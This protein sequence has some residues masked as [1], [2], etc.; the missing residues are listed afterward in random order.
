LFWIL[1]VERD[2]FANMSICQH[3]ATAN[4]AFMEEIS[5]KRLIYA[6]AFLL[7]LLTSS[8]LQ[9]QIKSAGGAIS[10]PANS[11]GAKSALPADIE[12][13]LVAR[14]KQVLDWAH[15]AEFR[16]EPKYG[17]YD[18]LAATA[19]DG[20]GPPSRAQYMTDLGQMGNHGKYF[21]MF[22]LPPLVRYLYMYPKCMSDAQRK[23][24]ITGLTAD[25]KGFFEHGTLNH[26][27]LQGTSWYLLA[28]YFPDAVWTD[29][30]GSRLTSAQIMAHIKDLMTRRNWR[31]FQSGMSEILSPTYSLTNLYPILNMIDFGKDPQL[32]KQAS[33][34]ASLEVLILKAHS[35][36]G[37]IMPPMTRHNND[38]SNAPM[39]KDWPTNA[40]IAQ[41]E[42][43]Y[44]FGEPQ[45][46]PNDLV[47]KV[48]EP[49]FVV[50]L[51][52]SSWRPPVGAWTMPVAN[53]NVRLNTPDFAKWDN[54][55]STLAFGDTWIGKN[56]ALAT[57]N[58]VFNPLGYND[59]NQTFAVAFRSEARRNL[60]E[61]QQPYW[62]SNEGEN[63]W[64]G[65]FWSPFMQSWRLDE[66]RAVL[67][68]SVPQKDP[69]TVGVEDR[70]WTE[71]DKH[72]NAL[73]QFVQCRI[74]KA[75]DEIKIE[76]H[77]V[78][79][80]KGPT[81]VALGSLHGDFETVKA[82]LPT[83]LSDDFTVVKVD[84]A[85]TALYV[86]ADDSGGTFSDFRARAKASAPQYSAAGPSITAGS[87][88]VRF[89]TP[90]ADPAPARPGTWLA[91][92][93]VTVNGQVQTYKSASV[94]ESPFLTLSNG[95]LKLTGPHPLDI[96]G[97][98]RP[99]GLR[100]PNDK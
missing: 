11:A 17:P 45:I 80:R 71:R 64:S 43:W 90:V 86:M 38:Q 49:V 47:N 24:L 22:A 88:T 59:H 87:T 79:F 73:L 19:R 15:E 30:N 46:G 29:L 82:G 100:D 61:C 1:R 60:L 55:T 96:H 65:D 85:K 91:L 99:T 95:E 75:V 66:H 13:K 92:P 31:S 23:E 53:Y 84:Q 21:E 42:L 83:L 10:H 51:A 34:E 12:A 78:F 93:E 33:D 5:L 20:C 81:Y 36:H 6:A 48:R 72:A 58:M 62:R 9:A 67:L 94:F 7:P 4:L 16:S 14:R 76:D 3:H 69:W 39:L 28:Q 56:Y 27:V 70:F 32:V 98:E 25:G 89:M 77:W 52:L 97:P 54:P 68:A 50:M 41:Q 8:V 37:V 44:Y 40:S 26:M 18:I 2:S 57:G 74:P 63:A 35:F